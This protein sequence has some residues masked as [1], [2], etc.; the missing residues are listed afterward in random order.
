MPLIPALHNLSPCFRN[1][2]SIAFVC[3]HTALHH[4]PDLHVQI[5][6]FKQTP[7]ADKRHVWIK[8]PAGEGLITIEGPIASCRWQL[9]FSAY[10]KKIKGNGNSSNHACSR[11]I[12]F[13]KPAYWRVW[14][15]RFG[16]P[17]TLRRSYS[18]QTFY[19]PL[20]RRPCA[21]IG[22]FE[23]PASLCTT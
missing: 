12:R 10:C 6:F 2:T 20:G 8:N 3:L 22:E 21:L 18:H 14:N 9:Y 4:H 13:Y 19:I 5:C 17:W 16:A 1:S 15:G 7:P 23:T 11:F